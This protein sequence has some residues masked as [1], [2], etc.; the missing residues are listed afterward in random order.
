MRR[1]RYAPLLVCLAL[2]A[3]SRTTSADPLITIAQGEP[4]TYGGQPAELVT[5]RVRP[6]TSPVVNLTMKPIAVPAMDCSSC[7]AAVPAHVTTPG[8]GKALDR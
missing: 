7:D 4:T 1:F 5:F 3:G 8:A 2:I 6:G